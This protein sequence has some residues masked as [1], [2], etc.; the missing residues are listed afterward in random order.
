MDISKRSSIISDFEDLMRKYKKTPWVIRQFKI[1]SFKKELSNV[2]NK[3]EITEEI[4]LKNM[5]AVG[6]L[7]FEERYHEYESFIEKMIDFAQVRVFVFLSCIFKET[8]D[9]E[10]IFYNYYFSPIDFVFNLL[11]ERNGVSDIQRSNHKPLWNYAGIPCLLESLIQLI[12][13]EKT[14][15]TIYNSRWG[16]VSCHC[17][18]VAAEHTIKLADLAFSDLSKDSLYSDVPLQEIIQNIK[19]RAERV[20]IISEEDAKLYESFLEINGAPTGSSFSPCPGH[21]QVMGAAVSK[22]VDYIE[23]LKTIMNE[24]QAILIFQKY[25]EPPI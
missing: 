8:L 10:N 21:Y 16:G 17:W 23:D 9:K 13:A 6:K 11:S 2:L 3:Y 22:H 20:R 5:L 25:I 1:A 19:G 14:K 15:Y 12:S 24:T 4:L 18:Q 7:R